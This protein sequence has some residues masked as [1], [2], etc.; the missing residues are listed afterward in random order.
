MTTESVRSRYRLTRTFLDVLCCLAD[1]PGEWQYGLQIERACG[2]LR[3][4]VYH[5]L[6]RLERLGLAE[7]HWAARPPGCRPAARHYY[8]L[9]A[10][11][12]DAAA[13]ARRERGLA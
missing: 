2:M 9:T 11:G 7:S 4:T 1:Q 5:I 3:G 13:A 8:R 10:A 6:G 12:L